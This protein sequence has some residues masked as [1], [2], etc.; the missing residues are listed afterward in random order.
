MKRSVVF[1]LPLIFLGGCLSTRPS[2]D[3]PEPVPTE[4]GT[5]AGYR[6][7]ILTTPDRSVAEGRVNEVMDWWQDLPEPNRPAPL[8]NEAA[9]PVDIVW[10]QPYYR[11]QIGHFRSQQEASEALTALAAQFPDA[12]IVPDADAEPVPPPEP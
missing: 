5:P 12:F 2:T 6:V 11:V 7:Q 9:L 10:R 1:L 8:A 3:E 4:S